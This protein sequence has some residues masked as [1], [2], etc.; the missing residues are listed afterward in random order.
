M[1]KAKRL[2]QKDAK[3]YLDNHY[4]SVDK[5]T[6]VK[7][8]TMRRFKRYERRRA[9]L[10][11]LEEMGKEVERKKQKRLRERAAR[12]KAVK[13]FVSKLFGTRF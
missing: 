2:N 12:R 13:G 5:I 1:N 6:E 7:A 11:E 9:E 4:G 3:K 8:D 10:A